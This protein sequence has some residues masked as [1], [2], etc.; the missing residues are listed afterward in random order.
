MGIFFYGILVRGRAIVRILMT[1]SHVWGG[2]PNLVFC[3]GSKI[4]WSTAVTAT[5]IINS[6]SSVFKT[7][8]FSFY[9]AYVF[10]EV[11]PLIAVF[12]TRY[13]VSF[14]VQY[15]RVGATRTSTSNITFV[16]FLVITYYVLGRASYVFVRA[17]N[18]RDGAIKSAVVVYR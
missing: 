11:S 12:M 4:W 9:G 10:V 1:Y 18:K 6:F 13:R 15:Q 5:F 7:D 14:R 8:F 3:V 16:C 2:Y 17:S